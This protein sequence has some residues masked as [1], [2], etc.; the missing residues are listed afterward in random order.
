MTH[1]VW[2]WWYLCRGVIILL[3]MSIKTMQ[4]ADISGRILG[5]VKSSNLSRP[6][7]FHFIS[8]NHNSYVLPSLSHL[9]F[10]IALYSSCKCILTY[11]PTNKPYLPTYSTAALIFH[12]IHFRKTYPSFN[13]QK[14]NYLLHPPCVTLPLYI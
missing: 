9:P 13:I 4:Y 11:L 3:E 2:R 6:R 10:L 8:H 7:V 14:I 12:F 5:A 1:F